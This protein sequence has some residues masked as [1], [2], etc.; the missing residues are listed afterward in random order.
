MITIPRYAIFDVE[1]AHEVGEGGHRIGKGDIGAPY[2]T[3]KIF[4]FRVDSLGRETRSLNT[5]RS[6]DG[7]RK[8]DGRGGRGVPEVMSPSRWWYICL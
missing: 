1:V 3:G 6:C 7:R 2:H 4:C 5:L 8:V